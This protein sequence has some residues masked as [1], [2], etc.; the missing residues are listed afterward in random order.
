M[1]VEQRIHAIRPG[2]M[3]EFLETLEQLEI[4]NWPQEAHDRCLGYYRAEFGELHRA[5]ALWKWDSLEQR[6]AFRAEMSA[7]PAFRQALE[8]QAGVLVGQRS[9]IWQPMS[10]FEI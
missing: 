8:R 10:F 1:F 5:M 7:I 9:A 4:P 3:N 2:G 6:D